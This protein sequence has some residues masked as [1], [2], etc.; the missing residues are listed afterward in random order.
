MPTRAY[1]VGSTSV[2]SILQGLLPTTSC[3]RAPSAAK[4]E[5]MQLDLEKTY[6]YTAILEDYGGAILPITGRLGC[7]E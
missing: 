7:A 2:S 1:W 5:L 4:D 6:Q 3:L